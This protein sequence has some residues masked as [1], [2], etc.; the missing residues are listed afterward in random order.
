[1]TTI[2]ILKIGEVERKIPN[3]SGLVKKIDYHTKILDIGTKYFTNTDYNKI[4]KNVLDT[5]IKE[6]ELVDKS[7]ISRK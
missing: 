2:I 7:D 6:M 1:M 4:L 5:M 3:V